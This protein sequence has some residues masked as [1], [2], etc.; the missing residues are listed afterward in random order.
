ML[1]TTDVSTNTAILHIVTVRLTSSAAI[2]LKNACAESL[3]KSQTVLLIDLSGVKNIAKSGLAALI[4]CY[5][6]NFAQ[7]KIGFFGAHPKIQA[8]FDKFGLTRSLPIF[9][10]QEQAMEALSVRQL[11]LRGTRAL[12]LCAGMGTRMAP[13]SFSTPKPMLDF[14]G[15]PLLERL[16]GH[17]ESFGIQDILLNPG[18]LGDQIVQNIQNTAS[19]NIFFANEGSPTS[20][21]NTTAWTGAPLGSASTLFRF[22][23]DHCA[24]NDDFVVLCGDAL[25]NIDLPDMLRHHR[26]TGAE[27]TIAVRTVSREETCK[28]GIIEADK[29]GRIISFQEKPDAKD[30]RS[31]LA[32]TGIYIFNPR[33]LRYQMEHSEADIAR[34]LLP[35]ILKHNSHIQ[36]YSGNFSWI[37]IGCCQDYVSA[38]RHALKGEIPNLPIDAV[39]LRQ[40]VWLAKGASV[41]RRAN[42]SG[43]CFI[44]ENTR[45]E[46]GAS[47]KGSCVIGKNCRLERHS[48][49]RNSVIYD[50][51]LVKS[52]AWV[53]QTIAG[54][55]WSAK[56]TLTDNMFGN[57]APTD[58]VVSNYLAVQASLSTWS[59]LT[60]V[61]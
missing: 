6:E 8:T 55:D 34:D 61:G 18:H 54:P 38:L 31:T 15:Q 44:G 20:N 2:V 21:E 28:Y 51:T 1:V 40:G 33:A 36:T 47:L 22:Q 53:D 60:K 56:L 43:P 23:R 11:P 35:I 24:F 19:R 16:I 50:G 25:T 26:T 45:V 27:V 17:L 12:I 58:G 10:N 30:A 42:I 37:D 49:V 9:D 3:E 46:A 29:T 52:G 48:L 32:S 13:L 57:F 41:S 39:E 14:L 7:L 5:S 4:E 59:L